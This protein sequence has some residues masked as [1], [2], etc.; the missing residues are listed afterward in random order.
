MPTRALNPL[1]RLNQEAVP[2]ED[3]GR[4]AIEN[5]RSLRPPALGPLIEDI[6]M[7]QG[8]RVHQL[9]GHRQAADISAH[10]RI[11]DAGRQHHAEGPDAFSGL[12]QEMR[13]RFFRQISLA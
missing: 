2:T 8:R 3:A 13:G 6:I 1:Q 4:V 7:Q 11:P 5:P 10:G 12:M 9:A